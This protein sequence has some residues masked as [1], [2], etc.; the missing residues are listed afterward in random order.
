MNVST[1]AL[2]SALCSISW[3]SLAI[4][5]LGRDID[6]IVLLR[7]RKATQR[8]LPEAV[9]WRP[10]D[11]EDFRNGGIQPAGDQVTSAAPGE[12]FRPLIIAATRFS[13]WRR[14]ATRTPSTWTPTRASM[15]L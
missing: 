13:R 6:T 12:R 7:R 10:G 8:R 2:L 14:L 9:P 4:G 5:G 15:T 11:H 1:A 3:R